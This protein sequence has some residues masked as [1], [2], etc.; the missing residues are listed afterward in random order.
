MYSPNLKKNQ[1]YIND[2]KKKNEYFEIVQV[3]N[4]SPS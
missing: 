2:K 1:F 4:M 3:Y